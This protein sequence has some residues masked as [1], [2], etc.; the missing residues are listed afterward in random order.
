MTQ[1]CNYQK[2]LKNTAKK[3]TILSKLFTNNTVRYQKTN[4][5]TSIYI[6]IWLV[7]ID[8]IFIT[9]KI[10]LSNIKKTSVK[11]I[12][13]H[14]I[15]VVLSVWGPIRHRHVMPNPQTAPHLPPLRQRGHI[16]KRGKTTLGPAL[17]STPQD[18]EVIYLQCPSQAESRPKCEAEPPTS[19]PFASLETERSYTQ[20]RQDSTLG[21]ALPSTPQDREVIYLQCPSQAES[22]PKCEITK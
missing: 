11:Y 5:F 17:P 22:R 19:A 3:I 15:V 8:I 7:N 13:I 9:I 6:H 12:Y 2:L 21:P 1:Y 14:Y 18:R 16:L 20:E 10:I 4:R